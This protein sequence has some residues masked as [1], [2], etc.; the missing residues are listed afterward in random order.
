MYT[1][2]TQ[3]NGT[4]KKRLRE[5]VSTSASASHEMFVQSYGEST[6]R[7]SAILNAPKF[8]DIAEKVLRPTGCKIREDA[9]KLLS[10]AVQ[11]LVKNTLDSTAQFSRQK[12]R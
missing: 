9:A 2:L 10:A 4:S 7:D 3:E 5:D 12:N 6:L 11:Q 1:S 8:F